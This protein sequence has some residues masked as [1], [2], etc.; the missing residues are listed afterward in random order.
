MGE[1]V[2]VVVVRWRLG[3]SARSA[4]VNIALDSN[5]YIVYNNFNNRLGFVWTKSTHLNIA[6]KIKWTRDRRRI[7]LISKSKTRDSS[8]IDI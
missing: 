7:D 8:R 6:T 2:V 1:V 4:G 5:I 3:R